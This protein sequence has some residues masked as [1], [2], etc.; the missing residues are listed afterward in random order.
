MKKEELL[1]ALASTQYWNRW[2]VFFWD[3]FLAVFSSLL[4]LG[5]ISYVFR[6]TYS[7]LVLVEFMGV[8]MGAYAVSFLWMKTYK[9]IIRHSAFTEVARIAAVSLLACLLMGIL[10]K[11]VAILPDD[12]RFFLFLCFVLFQLF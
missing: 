1:R 9:G 3:M 10:L 6:I 5:I 2:L 8:S 12:R 11:C 4:A 7:P